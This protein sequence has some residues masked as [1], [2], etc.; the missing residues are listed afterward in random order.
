MILFIL[1]SGAS[2]DSHLPTYRDDTSQR[3]E[4][5][6]HVNSLTNKERY[7]TLVQFVQNFKTHVK[8]S[9]I[10]E[11]YRI[12]EEIFRTNEGD[13]I[14]QNI[15][16]MINRIDIKANI[17]QVHGDLRTRC[18]NSM[19]ENVGEEWECE[20]CGERCRP[21]M[22]LYGEELDKEVKKSL[23]IIS[24]KRYEWL[25]IVGT[26]LQFEYLSHIVNKCKKRGTRVVC[27]NPNDACDC[28]EWIKM[29]SREGLEY[30]KDSYLNGLKK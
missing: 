16:G 4:E 18:Q 29:P 21:N 25:V 24:R 7:N 11:T 17:V 13:I 28:K 19:C 14:T 12:L 2:V 1:G 9:I 3:I 6:L 26:T 8:Q 23:S 5:V 15:D 10:G 22:V 20:L 27:I 30:F